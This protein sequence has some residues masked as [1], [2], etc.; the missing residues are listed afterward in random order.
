MKKS[1]KQKFNISFL[2]KKTPILRFTVLQLVILF[3][4]IN[5][6]TIA[7]VLSQR[8][9]A[10]APTTSTNLPIYE[11]SNNEV[12]PVVKEVQQNTPQNNNQDNPTTSNTTRN[13]D[14]TSND[15]WAEKHDREMAELNKRLA[16]QDRC[17][18]LEKTANDKYTSATSRARAAYDVVMAEWD[19]VKDLPYY[20]RHPYEQYET[21]AKTKHNAISKPAYQEY[22]N[23]LNGL[24]AQGCEITQLHTNTSWAGY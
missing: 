8:Q 6:G 11:A 4:A 12:E 21:D 22:V 2:K 10:D 14:T 5:S 7:V 9:Q 23:T 1:K 17:W 18:N 19:Q 13:T 24:R 3:V 16:E 15:A 20:Q